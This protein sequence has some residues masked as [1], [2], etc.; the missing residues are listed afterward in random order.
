MTHRHDLILLVL[1]IATTGFPRIWASNLIKNPGFEEG[2]AP[3]P[4]G[5][6]Y[7]AVKVGAKGAVHLDGLRRAEGKHALR[8]APNGHNTGQDLLGI[9]QRL[10]SSGEFGPG[11]IQ[12]SAQLRAQGG[13]TAVLGLFALGEGVNP[14]PA[15]TKQTD[16]SGWVRV[17]GE[18][19]PPAT[20][21]PFQIILV[22]MAEGTSGSAWFDDLQATLLSATPPK[23][24]S[25]GAIA[26]SRTA[27]DPQARPEVR[28]LL[29]YFH[30]LST[31]PARHLVTGQFIG[32]G[33]YQSFKEIE[34]IHR[35]SGQWVAMISNDYGL[36]HATSIKGNP[37]MIDY[38]NSGGLVMISHHGLN[39]RTMRFASVKSH[40]LAVE[41]V[42]NPDTQ[43]G[44]NWLADMHNVAGGL[45]ELQ[46]SGVVV[47]WRPFHEMNKDFFW[48]GARDA[49]WFKRLWRRQFELFTMTYRL[50]NLLWVYSPYQAS[51]AATYYPGDDVVDLVGMDA[52]ETNLEKIQGYEAMTA[53]GKPFGFT[54]FGPAGALFP[55]IPIPIINK[56]T[57]YVKQL[58]FIKARF[59]KAV[60][61]HAWAGGWGFQK[62]KNLEP[63]MNDPWL[64]NRDQLDWKA[65]IRTVP[66]GN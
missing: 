53:L 41:D 40:N 15:M 62:Q 8:L 34:E 31:K 12:F 60:F 24:S 16:T 50:H 23:K 28:Q 2:R 37:T 21:K 18:F 36:A 42:L 4:T 66:A 38:W 35:R 1:G 39:P 7:D 17:Q 20:S 51:D 49:E 45:L 48:W 58:D 32:H 54:E 9:A 55:L 29:A 30:S 43:T 26:S 27:A 10:G 56:D 44:K 33:D 64:V 46:K 6:F 47:L 14:A 61:L 63:F 59:P 11:H 5:W 19:I 13:A 57:D 65:V 22:C 52:Y 3:M 25:P